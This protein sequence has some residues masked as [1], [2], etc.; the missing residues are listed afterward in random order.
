MNS[1]CAR[2]L[3]LAHDPGLDRPSAGRQLADRGRVEIAVGGQRERPRDRGRGHVERV[4]R[5]LPGALRVERRPLAH[6]EA[7]LLVDDA[8]RQPGEAH[9]R[10]DQR[11]GADHEAELAAGQAPEG[12]APA[13]RGGRPGEQRERDPDT[14]DRGQQLIEG[15]RVLL[16]QGLGRRHQRRLVA[17]LERAQHR[18][19]GDHRLARADVAHQQPLHRPAGDQVR[20]DLVHGPALAA[21]ELERQRLEPAA[22]QLAGGLEGDPGHRFAPGPA[23]HRQRPLVQAQLLEGEP[24]AGGLRL[25]GRVGE[26]RAAKRVGL[27]AE[28]AAGAQ[29]G[30]QRLDRIAG[31][32]D[33]L[34]GPLAQAVR[35]ELPG[36]AVD[37]DDPGGVQPGGDR[38]RPGGR[39]PTAAGDDLMRRD[40]EAG[41]VELAVEQQP[42]ARTK[43]LREVGLVEPDRLHRPARVGDRGLDQAQVAPAGRA[44][45]GR[46]HTDHHRRLLADPQVGD[47][48]DP[49][50]VAV[51]VGHVQEQVADGL[52]PDRRGSRAQLRAG[53]LQRRDRRRE[54]ARPGQGA[55]LDPPQGVPILLGAGAEGARNGGTCRDKHSSTG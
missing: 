18:V 25:L 6:A 5:R 17:G 12:L 4:R 49:G 39:R 13:R 44:H 32:P 19:Q 55:Q 53:A 26:V 36:R 37:G 34:P 30:G 35:G 29:L 27:R 2:A 1:I 22:D 14:L 28:A 9:V 3:L 51:A 31:A 41:A 50:A 38:R 16:G 40:P 46:P 20:V 15:R 24:V 54:P 33:R 7:V 47:L 52:D 45:P 23:A 8:D 42:G 43:P 48:A 21:R 11:V 10:L